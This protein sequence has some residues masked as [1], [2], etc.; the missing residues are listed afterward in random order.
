MISQ[1]L[2]IIKLFIVILVC[3]TIFPSLGFPT[4]SSTSSIL[5]NPTTVRRRLVSPLLSHTTH[6]NEEEI[7][8][9]P[10][11]VG[12]VGAGA[13][14]FSTASILSKNGHDVM[15]WSPSGEGT[16][17]FIYNDDTTTTTTTR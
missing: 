2:V 4:T 7:L 3:I 11:K 16:K 12:I 5:Q 17:D 14:A 15:I 9:P 1:H 10:I 8:I 6:H 13:I